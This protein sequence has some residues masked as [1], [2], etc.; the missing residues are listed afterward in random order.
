MSEE[1]DLI[2]EKLKDSVL[3]AEA[4][5]KECN[6]AGKIYTDYIKV[7]GDQK[8]DEAD[9]RMRQNSHDDELVRNRDQAMIDDKHFKHERIMDWVDR[10]LKVATL[11]IGTAVTIWGIKE[12][13]EGKPL[14]G[15][16]K[17]I[18]SNWFMNKKV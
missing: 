12:D 17:D 3:K 18:L 7:I 8:K 2:L 5:S 1:K 13:K 14:F 6:E 10:G 11:V 4:G 16:A 9:Q 15:A